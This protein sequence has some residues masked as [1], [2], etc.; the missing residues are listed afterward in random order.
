MKKIKLRGKRGKGKFAL[1]DDEDFDIVN[2]F[3]WSVCV[4]GYIWHSYMIDGKQRQLSMHRLIINTP[5]GKETDHRD[6]DKFNNQKI[7]LRICT[8]S[9]NQMNIKI[10]PNQYRREEHLSTGVFIGASNTRDGE[11]VLGATKSLFM[12]ALLN[13]RKK[14]LRRITQQPLNY[15]ENLRI[16]IIFK[17]I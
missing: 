17:L 8:T 4:K 6:H 16:L 11:H 1:I 7:N 5:M 15:T 2:L 12:W 10:N 14:Q 3:S 13:Q 9:Q